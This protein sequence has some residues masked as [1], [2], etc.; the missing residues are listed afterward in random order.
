MTET[1]GSTRLLVVEDNVTT[2]R[3]LRLFLEPQGYDVVSAQNG[4]AALQLIGGRA[5]DLVL[6]DLM[7]P[8]VDGISVC[9]TI[10]RTSAIPIVML[11]ARIAADDVVEGLEAGADDYVCKPFESKVLL[12]RIRRCLRRASDADPAA[13]VIRHGGI[14]L[15]TETRAVHLDGRPV[16]LTRTEFDILHQLMLRPGRVLTR[17][18]LIERAIGPDFDGFDRTV[19]THIWSLRKKLGDRREG[20]QRLIVSEPGIGYRLSTPDDE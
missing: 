9:R 18:R 7:L 3:T 4:A 17:A 10:R 19:D 2:A 20:G 15:D 11:T 13:S 1:A 16:R 6:L 5:F 14:E 8:D 12:A